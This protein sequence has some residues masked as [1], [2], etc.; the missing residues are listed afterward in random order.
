NALMNIAFSNAY[1]ITGD[2]Q[3]R[4]Q[5][6]KNLQFL[7]TAFKTDHGML[8]HTWKNGKASQPGFLDDYSYLVAAL[9]EFAQV[10]GDHSYLQTA[11]ELTELVLEHFSDEASPFFFFTHHEQKDIPVRKKEIYDGATPSGNAVMAMNLYKLSI[12]HDKAEWR[13]RSEA[14]VR[15]LGEVPA[16]YPT[17]FGMWVRLLFEMI[18]G[19]SE[20]AIVGKNWKNELGNL[21]R[22]FMPHKLVQASATADKSYPLLADKQPG[23]PV[24]IYLC[25]NYACQKPVST[26]AEFVSLLRAK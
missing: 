5:A 11:S 19:T 1:A 22:V 14:M 7:L 2:D 13:E 26:L 23:D 9:I 6:E 25:K 17:S 10:S 16:K 15:A 3:Y 24:L 18:S 21:L 4:Q 20:V 12:L 8:H